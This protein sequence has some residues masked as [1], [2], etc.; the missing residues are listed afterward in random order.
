MLSDCNALPHSLEP[1]AGKRADTNPKLK[2]DD[3]RGTPS[4]MQSH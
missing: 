2:N 3:R 4:R 1:D